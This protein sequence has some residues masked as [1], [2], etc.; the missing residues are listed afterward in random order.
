[1]ARA[2]NLRLRGVA[3]GLFWIVIACVFKAGFSAL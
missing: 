1:M 3:Y 2:H